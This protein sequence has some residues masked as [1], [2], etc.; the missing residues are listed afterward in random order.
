MSLLLRLVF[1][2]FILLL[3]LIILTFIL[4]TSS[5]PNVDKS[6]RLTHHNPRYAKQILDPILKT[7]PDNK[8]T[9]ELSEKDLNIIANYV[10][11]NYIEGTVFLTL[12]KDNIQFLINIKLP[13]KFF[14]RYLNLGFSL[15]KP[16]GLPTISA[17]RVAEF[18]LPQKISQWLIDSAINY[19]PLN[20]YYLL[21]SYYV[22]DIHSEENKLQITYHPTLKSTDNYNELL[23]TNDEILAVY[24]HKLIETL[25]K[26]PPK[27]LLSLGTLFQALFELAVQRSTKDNAIEENRAVIFTANTYTNKYQI[28][29][30]L[31]RKTKTLADKQLPVYL[32]RRNDL[33]KH[34][35][36]SAALTL[37]TNAYIADFVGKEKE[38]QDSF[39]R[40]GFSFVDL[41]ANQAG[42]RFAKMAI[43]SPESALKLQQTM[44]NTSSYQ[45]FMPFV[46]NLPEH[47]KNPQFKKKYQ[48]LNSKKSKNILREIDDRINKLPL[49]ENHR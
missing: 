12:S 9:L 39:G 22:S 49:Y 20:N 44:A 27:Q 7:N 16:E 28:E 48:T 19:S 29:K 41:A 30:I 4:I 26:H 31:P 33:A 23:S 35:M 1:S 17:L 46:L 6:W 5:Q 42:I 2:S 11:N 25:V 34:F 3:G 37:T 18:T 24:Q 40:S 8:R 10:L 36:A 43:A 21:A 47:L 13:S 45:V 14:L 15:S 38:R 32:Y